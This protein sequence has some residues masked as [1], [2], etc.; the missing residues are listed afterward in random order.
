VTFADRVF[1]EVSWADRIPK[2]IL[3]GS[4][5][6]SRGEAKG[7]AEGRAERAADLI[8]KLLRHRLGEGADVEA[9]VKRLALCADATLDRI[10]ILVVDVK[11]EDLLAAV[12]DLISKDGKD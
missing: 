10:S 6:F 4:T 3:M 9:L 7:R 11:R 12:N 5:I 8:A 2:E 1:P